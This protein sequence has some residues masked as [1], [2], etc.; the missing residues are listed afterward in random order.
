MK[1]VKRRWKDSI[2]MDLSEIGG[3]G[4]AFIETSGEFL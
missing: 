1:S 2:E 4:N 3:R